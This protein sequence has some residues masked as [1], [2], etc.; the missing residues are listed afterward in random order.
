MGIGFLPGRAWP[1]GFPS[2]PASPWPWPSLQQRLFGDWR[3]ASSCALRGQQLRIRPQ[4]VRAEDGGGFTTIPRGCT[5]GLAR[6]GG[7]VTLAF[8]GGDRSLSALTCRDCSRNCICKARGRKRQFHPAFA[9]GASAERP[10]PLPSPR[11]PRS[12]AAAGSQ[13][14]PAPCPLCCS[15]APGTG[16]LGPAGVAGLG[17]RAPSR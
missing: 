14:P 13:P 12:C 1:S 3:P 10:P 6:L 11:V 7:A 9:A 8:Q 2:P 17:G 15:P 16:V 4:W 5:A